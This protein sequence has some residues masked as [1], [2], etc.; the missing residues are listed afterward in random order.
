MLKLIFHRSVLKKLILIFCFVCG[1]GGLGGLTE[2]N[3]QTAT[4]S[5]TS[6]VNDTAYFFYSDRIARY[7]L[8]GRNWLPPIMPPA[9]RAAITAGW[10]DGTLLL[11]AYGPT[12]YRYDAAGG[13]EVHLFNASGSVRSDG[14]FASATHFYVGFSGGTVSLSRATGAVVATASNWFYSTMGWS[15]SNTQS[16]IYAR[17]ASVS[18]S[19][20]IYM[21]LNA[22]GTF[23]DQIDSPYHGDYPSGTRTWLFPGENKVVDSSGVVY[24]AANL[25]FLQSFGSSITDL[26]FNGDIPIVLS[27]TN[28][29]AYTNTLLPVGSRTLAETPGAFYVHGADALT[30]TFDAT[31]SNAARI[32]VIPLSTIAAPTPGQP[33]NPAGLA[34]TPDN[35]FLDRDGVLY[36]LSRSQQSLFRWDP[37]T[38]TWLT[39]IPLLG[40]PDHVAYSTT[41]HAIY[42]AYGT[43]LVRKLDLT[44]TPLAEVP[45]VNLPTSLRGLSVAGDYLFTVDQTGAM[46]ASHST[47]DAA[48][49]RVDYRAWNH[50]SQSYQWS[51]VR[52]KMYFFRDETSP[53]D[54]LSQ[55]INANG[56]AYPSLA[57]GMIGA[58]FDSPL[59][60][61]DGWIH[62]IR[63]SPDHST[64]LLGSGRAH[65]AGTLARRIESIANSFTDAAW[66]TNTDL[67]T[68]RT[69]T[70][71]AQLQQWTG[72][73]YTPGSVLQLPGS[74][75][76]LF[77]LGADRMLAV[78]LDTFSRPAFYVVSP[79]QT[80]LPPTELAAPNGLAFTLTS[81]TAASLTWSDV[82][83]E[84]AY[85][86]QVSN[87]ATGPWTDVGTSGLSVTSLALTGLSSGQIKHYRVLATNGALRSLASAPV[88]L[89]FEL[90]ATPTGLSGLAS[91][92]SAILV[93]W[94]STANTANYVLERNLPPASIWTQIATPLANAIS[95]NSTGLTVDTEYRFRL[96]AVNALGSSANSDPITVRTQTLPT[97]APF[98]ISVT[99]IGPLTVSFTWSNVLYETGYEIERRFGLAA[100]APLASTGANVVS[101]TDA[102]VQ[103]LLAYEFRVRAINSLGVS[104]FSPVLSI[105]TP[106]IPPPT[107]PPT[108]TAAY[109]PGPQ[110]RVMW[111]AVSNVTGYL[112]QRQTGETAW[113]TINTFPSTTTA[114]VDTDVI[115]DRVYSYRLVAVGVGGDSAPTPIRT[116]N[117]YPL[118][119]VLEDNFNVGISPFAW[120]QTIGGS[121][122]DGG[123]GFGA[124]PVFWFGGGGSRQATTYPVTGSVYGLLEFR[125][126][127]GDAPAGTS[128]YWDAAEAGETVVLEYQRTDGAWLS[129]LALPNHADW[130]NYQ[131]LLPTSEGDQLRL[132]WRQLA[133]S[134]QGY[135]AWAIENVRVLTYSPFPPVP[136]V[137]PGFVL[138]SASTD[139]STGLLWSAAPGAVAYQIERTVN[140]VN[141]AQVGVVP[142]SQPY[143]TDTNLLPTTWYAYRVRTLTAGG[144]SVPS[145]SAW[146]RTYAQM[147]AWRLKNFGSTATSPASHSLATDVDG[148]AN[149]LKYAFN[150]DRGKPA[151]I[152][153]AGSGTS[154]LP[155]I[156]LDLTTTTLCVEY[157]RRRAGTA[158]GI[159]YNVEF[160]SDLINWSTPANAAEAVEE[161]DGVWQRVRFYDPFAP[162]HGAPRFG[163]VR[164]E[165]IAP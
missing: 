104:A 91:S 73:G 79:A 129:L 124:S 127:M 118:I 88:R 151:E 99:G 109:F 52:Q 13:N 163:R 164:V 133:H 8:A 122:L 58:R 72:S 156:R 165:E 92:S 35:G 143:Y 150:L 44:A 146:A 87:D 3:A 106:A 46:G 49:N 57:P 145:A 10:T 128:A 137:P 134:G 43:G 116:L 66:F 117:L 155:D 18:P 40:I 64:I 138:A 29:T 23:G 85:L 160:S 61:S 93:S 102:T 141:W 139:T 77:A 154:G 70:G 47:Y 21:V 12:L 71:L 130:Q 2:A 25:T 119:V 5:S 110:V 81:S 147:E 27:G 34:F 158:P 126:R 28:L 14:L 111:S 120:H 22:N 30:F 161:I 59:H 50:Y 140:L 132:R 62:P 125:F 67:R 82:T 89:V 76:R 51:S 65:D 97:S 20:I 74:A 15:Y 16:R 53:N 90:P 68:L 101:F 107:T 100:W 153:L 144:T 55:E 54:L 7:D 94:N 33:V 115:T 19:D 83:G 114:Y 38:Q 95:N 152:L 78:T 6:R 121:A 24:S 26:Q 42:I 108:F 135:D 112:L 75:H 56:T 136:P 69:I 37:L 48:G 80:I 86:V 159:V 39:T 11:I 113:A 45:F 31:V 9:G 60:S 1:L 149:L 96:R 36:L 142:S 162:V 131:V 123:A 32:G 98:T 4:W 17:S 41:Q 63:I 157:I 103:P 148:V 84:S 105:S